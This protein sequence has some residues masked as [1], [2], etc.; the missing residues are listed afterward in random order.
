MPIVLPDL[1]H[2]MTQ[3]APLG[4]GAAALSGLGEALRQDAARAQQRQ[5]FD[6]NQGLLRQ[7][8]AD[9]NM[10]AAN[11]IEAEKAMQQETLGHA[12]ENER[13]QTALGALQAVASGVPGAMEIYGPL[14]N[15]RGVGVQRQTEQAPVVPQ[16][17][18]T[19]LTEP[20]TVSRETANI[21]PGQLQLG[22]MP[23]M[24]TSIPTNRYAFTGPKGET[25]GVLDIDQLNAERRA[26][27]EP[28]LKT[29]EANAGSID[30]PAVRMA[31][32]SAL[33]MPQLLAEGGPKVL[34]AVNKTAQ[35]YAAQANANVRATTVAAGKAEGQAGT[36]NQQLW[37]QAAERQ[38]SIE[39]ALRKD[40]D[41]KGIDQTLAISDKLDMLLASKNPLANREAIMQ[42]LRAIAQQRFTDQQ[43][44]HVLAAGG[45]Q[46]GF[47]TVAEK[48]LG[49]GD[50][51]PTHMAMLGKTVQIAREYAH[52]QKIKAA[53]AAR[54]SILSDPI[55]AN[56]GPSAAEDFAGSSE[57]LFLGTSGG[58]RP[59]QRRAVGEGGGQRTSGNVRLGGPAAAALIEGSAGG[60]PPGLEGY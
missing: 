12:R 32:E 48:W 2:F 17:P 27:V 15:L 26:A 24:D 23:T 54:Q 59:K 16:A 39:G 7:Q 40:L 50:V 36:T 30:Q 47:E 53:Q 10:R 35:P 60:A 55:I 29:M 51:S 22:P 49:Q 31:V 18:E 41:T 9:Q 28:A 46:A 25:L 14:L 13:A 33:R 45:I 3:R 58:E 5:E 4:M 19:K 42:N 37:S 44:N 57:T 8:L 43:L 20:G 52:Q 21:S 6:I 38:R 11:T 56:L 34:E 1:S